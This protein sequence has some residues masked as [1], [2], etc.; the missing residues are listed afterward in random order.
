MNAEETKPAPEPTYPREVR[1]WV[2]P[3]GWI[4]KDGAMPESRFRKKGCT[5]HRA[6]IHE[7][8][9]QQQPE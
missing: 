3:D 7:P 8:I 5:L 1:V 2:W 9:E 4:T 6:T